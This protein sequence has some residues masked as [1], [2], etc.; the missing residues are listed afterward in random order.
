MS[1]PFM[2]EG[3][4]HDKRPAAELVRGL[5][6]GHASS[7]EHP[8]YATTKAGAGQCCIKYILKVFQSQAAR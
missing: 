8:N 3:A 7:Y 1:S 5:S 2:A 6:A 4:S